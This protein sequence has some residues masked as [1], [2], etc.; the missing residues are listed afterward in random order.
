MQP[1]AMQPSGPVQ[2]LSGAIPA[3]VLL[4]LGMAVLVA[5]AIFLRHIT[6][7]LDVD[8][9]LATRVFTTRSLEI[10]ATPA[11]VVALPKRPAS[12]TPKPR[13][14]PPAPDIPRTE[15]VFASASRLPA[16]Q[17][18]VQAPVLPIAPAIESAAS[19]PRA[20]AKV[21]EPV[22][23]TIVE[24][25]PIDT[26]PTKRATPLE[27]AATP[28]PM[29]PSGT[30]GSASAATATALTLPGSAH[31][32]YDAVGMSRGLNYYAVGELIWLHDGDSYKLQIRAGAPGFVG[33]LVIKPRVFESTGRLT[34]SGLAPGR[35]ADKWRSERAAH[36]DRVRNQIVFSA[37]APSVTFAAGVQD[38]VSVFLQLSAMVA[39]AP[40]DFPI[41]AKASFETVDHREL[42]LWTFEVEREEMLDLPGGQ[43]PTLKWVRKP[44]RQYD[45]TFELWL[46]PGL[47]YLPAR[48]RITDANGGFMDQKWRATLPLAGAA[49]SA[50]RPPSDLK[51]ATPPQSD[52]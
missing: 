26:L 25:D 11:A 15:G 48:I 39:G 52:R 9:P 18:P 8:A 33:A 4:G 43:V 31:L 49:P 45:Q 42:Q 20:Q 22:A 14:N 36:F 17:T 16:D 32:E 27:I 1:D 40:L 24:S 6:L 19:S 34:A 29:P 3:R 10:R 35:Y 47:S 12:R 21:A 44:R 28:P 46:A 41:G 38:R 37:N 2:R 7:G 5:H 50:A 13:P 30:S 23:P 51:N